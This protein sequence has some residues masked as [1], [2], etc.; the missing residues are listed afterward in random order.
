MPKN[1]SLIAGLITASMLMG[2][3]I[4][5][6]QHQS[7]LD[8]LKQLKADMAAKDKACEEA[9]ADLQTKNDG[10]SEENSVMKAKLSELGQD[11]TQMRTKAGAYLQDISEKQKQIAELL[12]AQEAAKRRAE[13]F[14]ALLDKFQAMI[15]SGNVKVEMRN[16]RMIVKMSDKIL[17]DP[18]K[19]KLKPEGEAALVEVTRI[20]AGLENQTF[21]VAGHTDNVP[22]R[23]ARFK[24]NWELS[25]A[26]AVNVVKFMGEN[27]L[28]PTRLSA[29]GYSEYDPV[30]DNTTEDGRAMNR[31]IEITLVPNLKDLPGFGN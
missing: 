12:K 16:G 6:E 26:R 14:K 18:G 9:K 11:L 10:L 19:D 7:V 15:A 25:T 3:G 20:L 5:K 28:D 21:Q 8:E 17:F 27:G 31:R 24:S 23:S 29:A 4:P 13:Q 22:I 30:G 1:Y 2:C